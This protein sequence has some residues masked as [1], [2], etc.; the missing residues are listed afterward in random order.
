[1]VFRFKWNRGRGEIRF[2]VGHA[3][4][5]LDI[6]KKFVQIQLFTWLNLLLSTA[7]IAVKNGQIISSRCKIDMIDGEFL[8]YFCVS[9]LNLISEVAL[10]KQLN[11]GL[12]YECKRL[13]KRVLCYRLFSD[14][15]SKSLADVSERI[16]EC[17]ADTAVSGYDHT[18]WTSKPR[19]KQ[20][21]T[22]GQT[23][24]APWNC[25]QLSRF[26]CAEEFIFFADYALN[27]HD[28]ILCTYEPSVHGQFL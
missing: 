20:L 9:I 1:M 12:G 16:A 22:I 24:S 4:K 8:T 13:C 19:L 27:A 23:K 2:R 15:T 21:C 11:L 5:L 28:A 26:K 7:M 17:S 3:C 6:H 10:N 25:Y 18:L 14:Q